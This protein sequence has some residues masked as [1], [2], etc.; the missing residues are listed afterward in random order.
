MLLQKLLLVPLRLQPKLLP[1]LQPPQPKLLL[2][3]PKLQPAQWLMPWLFWT[4]LRS[5]LPKWLA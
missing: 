5:T 2:P 1:V 4:R 3:P